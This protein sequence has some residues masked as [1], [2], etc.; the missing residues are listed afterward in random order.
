MM[1]DLPLL[2]SLIAAAMAGAIGHELAHWIVWK[3]TGRDPDLD[4]W[5]LCVRPRAGPR[6]TTV[7][8]R[9]SAASPYVIGMASV[10]LGLSGGGLIAVAF[11]AGMVQL[12][13]RVDVVT[14]VGK[15]EWELQPT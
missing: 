15:T 11:G 3:W 8:D 4:L 13:S 10:L 1:G 6:Q 9:V 7:G 2:V 5:K 12:P 14:M